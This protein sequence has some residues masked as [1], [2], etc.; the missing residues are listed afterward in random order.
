MAPGPDP[1]E[2]DQIFTHRSS[3]HE[4][5]IRWT[6]LGPDDAPPLIF[7]HGTPWS[8]RVW[9]PYALAFSSRFKVYLFDNPGYGQ[10][11]GLKPLSDTDKSS[12]KPDLDVSLAAQ[13]DAFANL[14]KH[15][16]FTLEKLPHVIVHDNGGLISL[17]ALILGGCKYASLCMID[18]VAIRPFGS[19]FFRLVAA[20]QN[21][22]TDIPDHIF[23]G[24][25]RSYIRGAASKPLSEEVLDMLVEP[26]ETGF[27]GKEGF[28]R[29]MVQADQRHAE[30]V[31]DRYG[32]VGQMM[33]VKVIWAKEDTWIPADRAH[34]LAKMVGAKEVTLIDAASH[35][36]MYD[37]PERLAT[38]LAWWLDK[39]VN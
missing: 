6:S 28:V 18:V 21:V 31:E 26:W 14:V 8:S 34:K 37:Q 4:F 30:E 5:I 19:P 38:E 39:V 33:P 3:S 20:N 17:R 9:V 13:A 27:Q 29:Q 2:L 12:S 16:N 7:V 24:L 25:V 35:L 1:T 10:S 32:E 22:F 23:P 15:W 11:P 36:V